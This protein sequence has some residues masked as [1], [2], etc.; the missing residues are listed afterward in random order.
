MNARIYSP[1]T[2]QQADSFLAEV[3]A[4]PGLDFAGDQYSGNV[5]GYG[6]DVHFSYDETNKKLRLDLNSKPFFISDATIWNQI[7]SRLPHE[8]KRILNI[9]PS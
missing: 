8:V 6:C 7:E 3:K 5:E 9:N 2:R 1:V 4:A